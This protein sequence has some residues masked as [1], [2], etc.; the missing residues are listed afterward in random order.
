[1]HAHVGGHTRRRRQLQSDVPMSERR[2]QAGARIHRRVRVR[3]DEIARQKSDAQRGTLPETHRR[4][5]LTNVCR[6]RT[7]ALWKGTC[8]NE[9]IP[10]T[11]AEQLPR[12]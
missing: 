9:R 1:M 7:H 2:L 5:A 10:P 3:F 6:T 12:R 8:L 4:L 11:R